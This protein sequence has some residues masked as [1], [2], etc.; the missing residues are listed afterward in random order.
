[1]PEGGISA[2]FNFNH[3][4]YSPVFLQREDIQHEE[5]ADE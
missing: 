2:D 3:F 5:Q 4:L 1:M